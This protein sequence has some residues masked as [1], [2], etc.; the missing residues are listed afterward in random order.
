M[1]KTAPLVKLSDD[2]LAKRMLLPEKPAAITLQGQYVRLEPLVIERDAKALFEASNGSPIT[3]GRRSIE[4]YD[5]DALI[6]RYMFDGPFS[7]LADFEASLVPYVQAMYGLCLCVFDVASNKQIGIVNL[8]SNTPIH[9]KIE[10]GGIWY[11]PVVQKTMANT[12]ATYLMLK[13]AFNLGYR[14]VE[15]KC[16]A[17]NERSRRAALR[18]GFTF[19]GIQES[20]MIAKGCNRDTAWYRIVEAEWPAVKEKLERLLLAATS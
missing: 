2:I 15:W 12:E 19:E 1:I 5:A 4:S 16:H 6:W 7:H 17:D 20:H 11:S 3:I 8:M 18:M 10:L 14:R 9:L 13:H